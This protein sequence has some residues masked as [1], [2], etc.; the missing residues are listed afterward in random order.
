MTSLCRILF[1]LP[2]LDG[3]GSQRTLVNLAGALPRDR[4]T[5]TLVVGRSDGPARDW[6]APHVPLV[7]LNAPRLRWTLA[8]LR[9]RMKRERPHILFS[10]MPDANV[11]ASLAVAGL[12]SRPGLILRETNS[13]RHRG[14]LGWLRR[15][16]IGWAYGRADAVVA[17][18][19]GVRE[20]LV[21]DCAL[22]PERTVTIHNPVDVAG[23]ATATQAVKDSIQE[24]P[25]NSPLIVGC[26]RLHRQKGFDLLIEAFADLDDARARL[27]I[28][29]EGPAREAL[30]DLTRSRGV[31]GRVLMPGFE[32][33]PEKWL[34]QAT[35]FVLPSRW[36]GFGHVLVEALA[37][38]VPVVS[39]WAPHGPADILNDDETGLMVPTG[40]AAALG[41]AIDRLLIDKGLRRRMVEAGRKTAERFSL[42]VIAG[43]YADLI[44][45]IA[46]KNMAGGNF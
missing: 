12:R 45:E 2:D 33:H 3:G 15:K 8:P 41:A 25:V 24:V 21:E 26:G 44:E 28:L 5:A 4:F 42:P 29:G 17:L 7:D 36:E 6:L 32:S 34:A 19:E 18:S 43:R 30:E 38:G 37:A 1:F 46:A 11:A 23:I 20:E 13:H 10:S 14:D 27:V 31:V 40:N 22:N 35:L 39:A 9:G 16:L